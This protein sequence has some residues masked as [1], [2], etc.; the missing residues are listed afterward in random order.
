MSKIK[1]TKEFIDEI[2]TSFG[3]DREDI[4]FI[5]KKYAAQFI[6]LAAEQAKVRMTN[7]DKNYSEDDHTSFSI[8][9]DKGYEDY[10]P[11]EFTVDNESILNIK[12]QIK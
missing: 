3:F 12:E 2:E 7:L 10:I 4:D 5:L 1:T 6:D 11:V 9:V 8:E